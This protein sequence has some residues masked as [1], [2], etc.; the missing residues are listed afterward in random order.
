SFE[1]GAPI[2]ENLHR[3]VLFSLATSLGWD[4]VRALVLAIGVALLGKPVLAA[5]RRTARRASFSASFS[6]SSSESFNTE[7]RSRNHNM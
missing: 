6:A 2:L 1:P 7:Q 3:F 4:L 5:L